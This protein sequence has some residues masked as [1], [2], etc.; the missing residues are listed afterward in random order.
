MPVSEL[1]ITTPQLE[2]HKLVLVHVYP[3]EKTGTSHV[4]THTGRLKPKSLKLIDNASGKEFR[5]QMCMWTVSAGLCF[6]WH[7]HRNLNPVMVLIQVFFHGD[8]VF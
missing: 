6:A 4:K 3:M 8:F 7:V 5:V 2:S 1:I